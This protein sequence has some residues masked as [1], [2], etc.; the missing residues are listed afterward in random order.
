M[1]PVLDKNRSWAVIVNGY[2]EH[3][4]HK[5][6]VQLLLLLLLCGI[7]A[8][9]SRCCWCPGAPPLALCSEIQME[10]QGPITN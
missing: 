7:V 1:P 4:S 8:I 6:E 5:A 2:W 3:I 10:L 9:C